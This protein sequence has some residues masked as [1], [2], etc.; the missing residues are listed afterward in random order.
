M[1]KMLELMMLLNIVSRQ[2]LVFIFKLSEEQTVDLDRGACV[3][4][5]GATQALRGFE[6]GRSIGGR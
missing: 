2:K 1:E 5:N 4:T 3:K 6:I